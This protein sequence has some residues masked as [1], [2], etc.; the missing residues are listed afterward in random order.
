MSSPSS[1]PTA[2]VVR[3]RGG[4]IGDTADVYIGTLLDASAPA[5]GSAGQVLTYVAGGTIKWSTAGGTGTVTSVSVA[6]ANGYSGTVATNT[7]TPAIT[8]IPPTT[9]ITITQHIATVGTGTVSVGAT[10][11]DATANDN[12]N[13]TLVNGTSTTITI[14]GMAAGQKVAVALLQDGTGSCLATYALS[15]GTLKWAGGSA[16]TLSTGASKYD[17]VVFYCPVA[18]TVLGSIAGQNY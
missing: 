17:L 7:T 9:G 12:W 3:A 15:S 6:T 10:T 8:I 5:V 14:S 16:P 18:G 13:V 2:P 4:S 11:L 1:P